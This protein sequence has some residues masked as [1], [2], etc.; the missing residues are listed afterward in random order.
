M[1]TG[2]R[3]LRRPSATTS[4]PAAVSAGTSVQTLTSNF[5]NELMNARTSIHKLHLKITG[6][7]SF[8]SHLALNEL[9]DALPDHADALVEQYQGAEE[10]LLTIPDSCPR[11]LNSKEEGIQYIRDI[12]QMATELQ[13]KMPHTEIVNDIDTIK[14]TLNSIKYKLLF[15]K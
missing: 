5:A 2:N 11:T 14:S 10:V 8:A 4:T 15:L 13:G 7:G 3:M 12:K 9:Y 6:E 1:N